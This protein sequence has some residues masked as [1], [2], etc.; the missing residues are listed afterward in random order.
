MD[1]REFNSQTLLAAGYGA[2]L[3]RPLCVKT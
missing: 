3:S 1:V 2:I